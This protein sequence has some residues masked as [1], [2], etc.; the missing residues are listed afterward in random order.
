MKYKKILPII[1][2]CLTLSNP[3]YSQENRSFLSTFIRDVWQFNPI[4][5]EIDARVE[6]ARAKRTADSKWLSNPEIGFAVDNK[7]KNTC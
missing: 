3:I 7:Q 1:V 2:I 4:L 6:V 5:K